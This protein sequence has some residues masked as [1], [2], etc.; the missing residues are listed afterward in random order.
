MKF[1]INNREL[2][3]FKNY[4]SISKG[5]GRIHDI[6]SVCKPKNTANKMRIH[7]NFIIGRWGRGV[8]PSSKYTFRAEKIFKNARSII[9]IWKKKNRFVIVIVGPSHDVDSMTQGRWL[10][11]LV[12]QMWIPKENKKTKPN[13]RYWLLIFRI[14]TPRSFRRLLEG[15]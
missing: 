1:G 13:D 3:F 12:Q 8:R 5:R 2:N 14:I 9:A 10:R 7:R 4:R 6:S 15:V 11:R